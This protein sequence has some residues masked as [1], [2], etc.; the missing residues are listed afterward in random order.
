MHRSHQGAVLLHLWFPPRIIL[1]QLALEDLDVN[2]IIF[3]SRHRNDPGPMEH[4]GQGEASSPRLAEYEGFSGD[5]H[6]SS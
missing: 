6:I 3:K 4:Q 2:L 5:F 1:S